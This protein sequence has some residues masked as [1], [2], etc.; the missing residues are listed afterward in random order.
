MMRLAFRSVAENPQAKN[1]AIN[2]IERGE[3]S[4][5]FQRA[6][7]VN[8]LPLLTCDRMAVA[9]CLPETGLR[10]CLQRKGGQTTPCSSDQSGLRENNREILAGFAYFGERAWN[11][12][13]LKTCWRSA[14][15]GANFSKMKRLGIFQPRQRPMS[16]FNE[17]S[18]LTI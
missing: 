1:Q 6:I 16:E 5:D 4:A 2:L 15:S 14:Q 12:S 17:R 11:L 10:M 3:W 7:K 9:R 13:A 18:E 8:S